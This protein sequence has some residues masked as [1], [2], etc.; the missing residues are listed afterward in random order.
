MSTNELWNLIAIT[1]DKLSSTAMRPEQNLRCITLLA[2][3]LDQ[4]MPLLQ[5]RLELD[6][7]EDD[8]VDSKSDSENDSLVEEQ[9]PQPDDGHGPLKTY[10]FIP[11]KAQWQIDHERQ[12]TA[13]YIV[14]EVD[15]DNTQG[16]EDL[17]V[18]LHEEEEET[19]NT[20]T[21]TKMS[22]KVVRNG[23]DDCYVKSSKSIPTF[24][25]DS[26]YTKTIQHDRY[27]INF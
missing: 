7:S 24:W 17:A 23:Q 27:S 13:C 21:T 15:D 22:P 1:S 26:R 2:E 10:D 8:A 25:E 9:S 18:V 5:A 12:K 14:R 11:D 6:S 20:S 19:S 4:N 3:T 16:C